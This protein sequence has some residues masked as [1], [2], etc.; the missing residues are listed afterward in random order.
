MSKPSPEGSGRRL[1]ATGSTIVGVEDPTSKAKLHKLCG[2][3]M[4]D[5]V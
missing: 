3:E 1:S 5:E 4:G 2:L